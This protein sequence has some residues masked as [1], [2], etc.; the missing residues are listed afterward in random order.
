MPAYRPLSGGVRG[1]RPGAASGGDVEQIATD[2]YLTH[3]GTLHVQCTS[4]PKPWGNALHVKLIPH[5][6]AMAEPLHVKR[7]GGHSICS[8][9]AIGKAMAEPLHVQCTS[10]PKTWGTHYT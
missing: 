3:P 1:C 2:S 8:W 6:K 4:P 5:R 10:P 7:S 9:S